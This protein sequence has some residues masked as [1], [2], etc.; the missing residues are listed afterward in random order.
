MFVWKLMVVVV[1]FVYLLL[2]VVSVYVL[3]EWNYY[4]IEKYVM[5]VNSRIYFVWI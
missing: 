4:W 1:F 3:M 2:I 5:G